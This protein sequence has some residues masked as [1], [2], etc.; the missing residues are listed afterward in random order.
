MNIAIAKRLA[1]LNC[2]SVLAL[3]LVG[4][5]GIWVANKGTEI[6]RKIN[7]E[8]QIHLLA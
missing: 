4:I 8:G 5:V 2:A 7:D 6:I 1:L 3:L